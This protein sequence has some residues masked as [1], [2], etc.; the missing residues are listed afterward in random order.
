MPAPDSSRKGIA[1]RRAAIL[2]LALIAASC[3][4]T[5]NNEATSS[6]PPSSPP[7]SA[8][9]PSVSPPTPVATTKVPDTEGLTFTKAKK[10][11]MNAGLSLQINKEFSHN[12]S[13]SV[14]GTKPSAGSEVPDGSVV[15]VLVAM[16]YPKIPN[17]VGES[18]SQARQTL[19]QAGFDVGDV[20]KQASSQPKDTVISQTPVAGTDAQPGRNVNL[21]IAKPEPQTSSCTPGYSP[22]IPPGSDVDCAGGSG[23]GPRYVSGPVRVTGSDPYGLDGDNDGW[24]CE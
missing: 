9:A 2:A 20:H 1:M 17:V 15:Q 22:C 6:S 7:T 11:L 23:D 8:T 10:L 16:A 13:G 14:L 21:V 24:G 18:L 4:R 12:L 3:T 19:K 5:A